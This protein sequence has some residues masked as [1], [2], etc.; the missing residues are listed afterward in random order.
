MPPSDLAGGEVPQPAGQLLLIQAARKCLEQAHSNAI[1]FA[2][3]Q[4]VTR[5]V[6]TR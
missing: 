4:A 5:M 2:V 1:T 3:Q 6:A